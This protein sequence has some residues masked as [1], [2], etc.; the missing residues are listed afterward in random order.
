MKGRVKFA[1]PLILGRRVVTLDALWGFRFFLEDFW[2][3]AGVPPGSAR[4]LSGTAGG[5]GSPGHCVACL[6]TARSQNWRSPNLL[7]L[8]CKG[9]GRKCGCGQVKETRR[10]GE[11]GQRRAVTVFFRLPRLWLGSPRSLCLE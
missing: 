5:E 9:S 1:S 11:R 3:C 7:D 8:L 10:R 2:V 4:P 6:Q